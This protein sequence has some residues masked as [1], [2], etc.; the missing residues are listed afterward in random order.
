MSESILV[1]SEQVKG[2]SVQYKS[3]MLMYESALKEMETKMEI[4]SNEFQTLYKYN[5][6]EHIKTRI[7]SYDSISGKMK[8]KELDFT[9]TNIISNLNDIAGMRIVCSFIP[10][11]YKIVEMLERQEDIKVL[12]H[13][14]YI[15]NPKKS[16]YSSYHIIVLV[17]VYLSNMTIDVKVEIQIRTMAM[18]FWASLEH[19]IKYKCG[20]EL[21]KEI[22][23]ELINCAKSVRKLDDKMTDLGENTIKQLSSSM[24]SVY[25]EFLENSNVMYEILNSPKLLS[26][27]TLT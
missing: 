9:Y 20:G 10:D 14:D 26:E 1:K 4:I 18:D 19:K 6:I 21:P 2:D 8:K 13:K 25:K 22:S 11:V 27:T 12:E 16:G 3:I 24:E 15:K 7:K 23:K 5:P 17:P